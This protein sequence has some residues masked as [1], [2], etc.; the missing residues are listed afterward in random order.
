M[1]FT[2]TIWNPGRSRTS[3]LRVPSEFRQ[4]HVIITCFESIQGSDLNGDGD[5][6]DQVDHVYF[7]AT[8]QLVSL[9]LAGPAAFLIKEWIQVSV[10]EG[11]QGVDLND[12]GDTDDIV[13]HLFS[14]A[15]RTADSVGFASSVMA[16]HRGS[17]GLQAPG[18]SLGAV[19]TT[20]T[21]TS[22][23]GRSKSTTERPATCS[24]PA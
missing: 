4:R 1:F 21:G 13:P 7:G 20:V 10:S 15:T 19:I 3:A 12:D 6:S 23:T 2:R 22:T 14:S 5:L 17:L 18:V 8:R 9:E 11:G 24:R 16:G